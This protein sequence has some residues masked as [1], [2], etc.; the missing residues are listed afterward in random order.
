MFVQKNEGERGCTRCPLK[1]PSCAVPGN[2]SQRSGGVVLKYMPWKSKQKSLRSVKRN[3]KCG[4]RSH[5]RSSSVCR[6]VASQ[7]GRVP[8]SA[9]LAWA[10]WFRPK[11]RVKR[12]PAGSSLKSSIQSDGFDLGWPRF[13]APAPRCSCSTAQSCAPAWGRRV[14]RVGW[15]RWPVKDGCQGAKC[16]RWALPRAPTLPSV[17]EPR[18]G[19]HP[20]RQ[21]GIWKQ[22][23]D[24]ES[25]GCKIIFKKLQICFVLIWAQATLDKTSDFIFFLL[26]SNLWGT[27]IR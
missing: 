7:R 9:V 22:S 27:L 17:R 3:N 14:W 16:D 10:S 15:G 11:W 21:G 13:Q 23:V 24:G 20:S 2:M 1:F 18:L 4:G 12:F 6:L 25:T 5:F 19:P 8:T 26:L